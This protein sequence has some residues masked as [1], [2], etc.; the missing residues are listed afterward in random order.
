[1]PDEQDHQAAKADTL[2]Q[3]MMSNGIGLPKQPN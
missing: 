2:P 1:V 3:R